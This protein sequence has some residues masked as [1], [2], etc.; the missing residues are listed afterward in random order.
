MDLGQMIEIL[1]QLGFSAI[2]TFLAILLWSSTRD[3]AW[4]FVVLGM[5]VKFAEVMFSTLELF[6]I[7]QTELVLLSGVAVGKV[8]LIG[9]PY[10]LFSIA[11]GIMVIRNRIRYE[12]FAEELEVE[13]TRGIGKRKR[14]RQLETGKAASDGDETPAGN[15][16]PAGEAETAEE[17]QEVEEVEAAEEVMDYDEL[18]DVEEAEPVEEVEEEDNA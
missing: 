16:T 7:V 18:D 12:A 11:F 1:T 9:L 14:K 8:I 10:V 6:G 13:K 17:K 3:A 15:E 5:I 4:M 2:A